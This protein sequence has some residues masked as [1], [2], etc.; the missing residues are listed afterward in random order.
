MGKEE[1]YAVVLW[2]H[3]Y[4]CDEFNI[5]EVR[6]SFSREEACQVQANLEDGEYNTEIVPMKGEKENAHQ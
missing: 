1:K 3:G 4:H 6:G 5:V 2:E